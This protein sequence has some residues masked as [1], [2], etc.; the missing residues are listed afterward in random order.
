MIILTFILLLKL[1][2]KKLPQMKKYFTLFVLLIMASAFYHV[3]AQRNCGA[4]ENLD[5][6]IDENPLIRQNMDR[7]EQFTRDYLKSTDPGAE[8]NVITI[9][10]VAHVI[11]KYNS[12]NISDEQ[13][14]SQIDV[15]N[16]DFRRANADANN[17]WSQ[18]AD[19][20]IEFCLAT[21]DPDG[22]QTN[23]INRRKTNKPS[24]GVND[25]MKFNSQ[26][27]IDAWPASDYLN[28]WV[29]NLTGGYLGY[30]QFPG[31]PDATDGVVVDYAYF[32]TIGTATAPFDLGRTATHEVGHW[33]NLR[34]IWGDGGCSV[35]DFVGD[36]PLSDGP[37]YG[38]N[39]GHVSC[40][41]VDMV[42][43]Y[44]D[45]TDDA[46]MNLFTI[47]QGDRMNALFGPGG[48]R[49][50]LLTSAGCGT[51]NNGP[52]CSDGVQNGDETG[53]DC[54]G[55]CDP[56][57]VATC[58]DGVQNGDETGIDCGG[59]CAPCQP[60][61][62]NI[63][64][65]TGATAIKKKNARLN[66][67]AVSGA[68]SYTA[69]YRTA[70]SSEGWATKTT[71][72]T[73]VMVNGLTTGTPYEW[74]VQADCN[75]SNEWS[76]LCT[77]T[78]GSANSSSCGSARVVSDGLQLMPNPASSHVLVKWASLESGMNDLVIYNSVGS[79][80]AQRAINATSG[81]IDLD[82]GNWEKGMYVVRIL[83]GNGQVYL[84]K[85]IVQ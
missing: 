34:H 70:G 30:A 8:R 26:G 85:L 78:A 16:E 5:R 36:T 54:G 2:S 49:E 31:G 75:G 38:C 80:I 27:G 33:L 83:A 32:G 11:Y 46:C 63:P 19:V 52:T 62:C 71:T 23:G 61:E 29:C 44:M 45:Y 22:N 73:D 72:S 28:M 77:F 47:G 56:C 58:T 17:T 82:V 24:F 79:V 67:N 14:Q 81:S 40:G 60:A 18:A 12:Q 51:P 7:I 50:G 1:N 84:Q 39:P 15:L 59:S 41:T 69:R 6:L 53:I 42:Q 25:Q 66:W 10:V 4:M 43:N 74:Q 65:A 3:E 21:T 48:F 68:A 35:D 13:I 76:V 20:M 55:S 64:V 9:P 57:E 37:N